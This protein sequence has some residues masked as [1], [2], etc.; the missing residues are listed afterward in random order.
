MKKPIALVIL[1]GWGYNKAYEFNAIH[2]ANTP[3]MDNYLKQY[4]NTRLHTS[5]LAVGLP[6][7]QMGNS[8]VGH[9]N[10]GAGRV[11][12]QALT[13][14]T[15]S[16]EDGDF[17]ENEALQLAVQTVK[18]NGSALH[19]MG[20]FSPGGVHS[21]TEHIKGLLQL[22]KKE[23]LEK[24]YLHAFL[25][26]RDTPPQ[27]AVTFIEEMEAYMNEESIGEIAS[28]T[29]RYYAM[30]RDKRWER[31]EK[32]YNNLIHADGNKA[33][34]AMEAIQASYAE[35][36]NDEF[37]LPTM[38]NTE[39]VVKDRDA[40]VFF[41]F[42]PDRAREITR[43]FV[44][45]DFDGFPREKKDVTYVCMTEYDKTIEHVSVAF[46]PETLN[47]TLGEYLSNQGKTQLRI[48]ETEKYAHV[49]FFFNGGVEEPEKGESRV[50]INSPSVAT[51]DLKPEMSAYEVTAALEA[52]IDKDLHDVIILNFA[53]PDMVGHTGVLEAAIKAVETVDEC[54]GRVVNKI[55]SKEGKVLITADH[56]NAEEMVNEETG[57]P[58][59]AHTTFDV[60]LIMIGENKELKDDGR[61]CDLAPTLLEMM[62]LEIPSEMTGKS[63]LK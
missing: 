23:N 47:N 24:V 48:A 61:L 35:G 10:I 9:L 26:G 31:V 8:E 52:E 60:P 32:A 5:G 51:Y 59:T 53:N 18:E 25:D 19:L 29:G 54:L 13:R 7:G 17:F 15:K 46:K 43:A 63:L 20:L 41:N 6:N 14:I 30:D 34:S 33:N 16:I 4:P 40:I 45:V 28:I 38:I 1:D 42:R 36:V 39:A 12:Y 56:G 62:G 3:N 49:T 50:L 22:A 2:L 37:V 57:N 27:S 55:L 11:V 21:H 58:Q 44:D